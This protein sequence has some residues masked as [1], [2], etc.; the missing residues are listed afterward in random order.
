MFPERALKRSIALSRFERLEKFRS[1]D[2]VGGGRSRFSFPSTS[3]NMDSAVAD[4]IVG[5]REQIRNFELEN[6]NISGAFRR[7]KKNVVGRGIRLNA[8]I[9]G[10]PPESKESLKISDAQAEAA[11][12]A[13]E[14]NFKIWN[15]QADKRL[16][17]PFYGS[18]GIQ[19][20]VEHA[21]IRDNE[22]LVVGRTSARLDRLIPYCLEVLEADRL[23]TPP[24]EISNPE[25][26]NGMHFDFEGVPKSYYV[27]K[28]H[29]G[30]T[31]SGLRDDDF[32][33]IPAYNDNGT[34]KV[35]FLFNPIRPE[36]TRAFSLMA[37]ALKD[38]QD[39][40]RYMDAE[41]LAALE[42]A[43]LVG[44]IT[45]E[46]SEGW[47]GDNVD[48]KKYDRMH[49]FSPNEVK[50]LS[51]GEKL[52]MH[53][54]ERPGKN[55]ESFIEQIW[56]GPAN[57]LDI[58]PEVFLQKWKGMNYSNARTVLLQFYATCRERQEFLI[59]NLNR[60]VYEN[61]FSAFVAKGKV[62]APIFYSR[63]D[64]WLEHSWIAPGWQWVDPKKEAD[65]K[66]TECELGTENISDII[67]AQG[68][69]PRVKFERRAKEKQ[70]IK[71]LEVKY[72]VE[73][74][75]KKEVPPAEEVSKKTEDDDDE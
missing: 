54:P 36:Q 30:S 45:T 53:R 66:A 2:A 62:S 31:I 7:L 24:G 52:E 29:P 28:E 18:G 70:W 1:M 57:S 10:D 63:K 40:D 14:K 59:N 4:N 67:L 6:G 44:T 27:L 9:V 12:T 13:S 58:P 42:D 11:N 41:K 16:M 61:V 72:G 38:V 32:E 17:L 21:L 33:E 34:K 65:G 43:C 8:E 60:P 73:L 39:A 25:V 23:Q 3:M 5:L 37:S 64:D 49:E 71:N 69:D 68:E 55:F 75:P 51:P 56:S 46:D 35:M 47:D 19:G 20:I 74:F 50:Y 15:R 22:C 48:G 26:E